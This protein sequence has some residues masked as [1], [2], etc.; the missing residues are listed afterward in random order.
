MSETTQVSPGIL[1]SVI[2]P[3]FRSQ[4]TLE[5]LVM[6]AQLAL[7]GTSHEIVFVDD[8]SPLNTWAEIKRLSQQHHHVHGIRLS[9]N[10]GQHSALLAGVRSA[11]GAV[12][13]TIDDDLQNPPEEIPKLLA[14]L[15]DEIDLVYGNPRR[16]AQSWWRRWSSSAVRRFL[17]SV[18]NADNVRNS[19][20]FRAFKTPLRDGFGSELGP[21]VS[22][23]ALLSWATTRSTSVEVEHAPREEGTSHFNLRRLL[24][25]AVDTITGYSTAPL[26]AV[27]ALGFVTAF[28]GL[29]LLA[30]VVGR[31]IFA[32]TS[33]P[34][35]AFLAS[36]IALFSGVQLMTLG[37]IGEYLSRMHFRVMNKPSYVIAE[38]TDAV[39]DLGL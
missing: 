1:I 9:R 32:G 21:S 25:F 10:S 14:C 26:Q 16:I 13:V 7:M 8:G 36:T 28:F 33:V 2:V 11:R 20:S 29:G 12:I 18:L 15:S 4:S 30:W 38:Q 27:L 35:F 34:G 37:V 3:V 31:S 23:D 39:S 5:P 19:S 6:R 24:R 17:G 22:L